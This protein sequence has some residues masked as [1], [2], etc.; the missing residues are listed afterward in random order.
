MSALVLVTTRPAH[1]DD[2]ADVMKFFRDAPVV[3]VVTFGPGD[4]AFY[5][6]GHNAIRVQD[7]VRRTDLVYNFGTF[8]FDSPTL[9][10]DFLAG[11]FR[12]W[13]SVGSFQTTLQGYIRENRSVTE[14]RLNLSPWAANELYDALRE[15]AKPE[16]ASYLYD[17]YR[18]NCSTRVRDALDRALKGE[19][20]RRFASPARSTFRDHTLRLVADDLF[21]YLGLDVA[22]GPLIDQ[23]LTR[24]DEMFLPEKVADALAAV[25]FSGVHGV[26]SLVSET[27]RWHEAKG[28]A[29]LRSKP[30]DRTLDF[31]KVGAIVGA[32]FAFMGWESYRR[33]QRWAE[34]ALPLG[35]ALLGLVTG[36]LGTLLLGLWLF[37]NH[38]VTYQNENLLQCAPWALGF[39]IAAY[40][41]WRGRLRWV[42]FV[43]RLAAGCVAAS[44]LGLLLKALPLFAQQNQRFIALFVPIWLGVFLAST[45]MHQKTLRALRVQAREAGPAPT[46]DSE[47]EHESEPTT[48][49]DEEDDEEEEA[50]KDR[51]PSTIP[52]QPAPA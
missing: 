38:E 30:P 5:K 49:A 22:M 15:N 40:G 7:K 17:Y 6:F 14:Q 26:A 37:T 51:K 44:I 39:P 10:V 34:L 1:A 32:L 25:T 23:P 28:R 20:S 24:Y 31:F 36:V 48:P 35:L 4:A 29:P 33:R 45:W 41:L 21:I 13:L 12:Y 19:L 52:P 16:N 50:P 43:Q 27:K 42:R 11:K 9:I 8:R 2:P 47:T 46:A 18:D 3:S